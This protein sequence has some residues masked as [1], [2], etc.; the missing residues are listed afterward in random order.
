MSL[1][2]FY[3]IHEIL[4]LTILQWAPTIAGHPLLW[5]HDDVA[6]SQPAL[7]IFSGERQQNGRSSSQNRIRTR[8]LDDIIRS[9][10]NLNWNR[11]YGI[12]PAEPDGLHFVLHKEYQHNL[13]APS[14]SGW[15]R[16]G[17]PCVLCCHRIYMVR[18]MCSL[19][20]RMIIM[21]QWALPCTALPIIITVPFLIDADDDPE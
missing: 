21:S 18:E 5:G 17:W 11:F 16:S 13:K 14:T 3:Y 15:S 10:W 20:T 6:T 4:P 1:R 7:N 19:A 9:R 2:N 8:T 12:F